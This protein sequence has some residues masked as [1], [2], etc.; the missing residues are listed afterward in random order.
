LEQEGR[1]KREGV[2]IY[3][4]GAGGMGAWSWEKE[5]KG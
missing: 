2:K 4:Q 1:I 5:A 3:E